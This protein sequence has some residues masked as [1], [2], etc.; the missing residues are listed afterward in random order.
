MN[1]FEI[2]KEDTFIRGISPSTNLLGHLLLARIAASS[3]WT[4]TEDFFFSIGLA[5]LN[6]SGTGTTS[7]GCGVQ[8]STYRHGVRFNHSKEKRNMM[9]PFIA[10]FDMEQ[11]SRV[12]GCSKQ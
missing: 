6:F 8:R 11:G 10:E 4:G 3:T 9:C 12:T 1:E 7:W 2:G 5:L